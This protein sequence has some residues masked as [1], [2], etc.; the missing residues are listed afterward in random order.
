MDIDIDADVFPIEDLELVRGV[1]EE[2]TD[3][4]WQVRRVAR[5]LEELDEPREL[6]RHDR[7]QPPQVDCNNDALCPGG[8]LC[9][10]SQVSFGVDAGAAYL[11]KVADLNTISGGGF[12][13]FN[14]TFVAS[15]PPN[16]F[17]GVA[18]EIT[19][20]TFHPPLLDTRPASNDGGP[21]ESCE[22]GNL[23]VSNDVWYR[24]TA[25]ANGTI[26]VDTVGS[27]YDTVL[28]VFSGTCNNPVQV[29][30]NDNTGGAGAPAMSISAARTASGRMPLMMA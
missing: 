22:A 1:V 13:D 27:D 7:S 17:C 15:G 30:C 16:D 10:Q 28:A 14:L 3:L 29:A 12:L 23:G 4:E 6:G 18:T 8:G 25:P 9:P 11:I 19:T 26:T 24:Y 20:D 21:A 2:P 5:V